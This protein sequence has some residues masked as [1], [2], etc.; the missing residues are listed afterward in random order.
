VTARD[1][2]FLRSGLAFVILVVV[3]LVVGGSTPGSDD[4]AEVAAFYDEHQV[5]QFV[6]TFLLAATVPF[7]VLFAVGLAER[8]GDGRR[9]GQVTVAGAILAGSAIL[10][11]AAIHFALLD[12]ADRNAAEPIPALSALDGSTWVAF[13]AGFGVMM[14]GAGGLL[15]NAG[16]RRWLGGIALVLGIALFVPFADF[17]A[18]L[19]TLV[20]IVVA[21][22][23]LARPRVETRYAVTPS[24]A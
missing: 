11:T 4:S 8:L 24:A 16:A 14:L 18:L 3:T 5:R 20:W 21:T 6:V 9:W 2:L 7:L 23:A 17:V 19:G 22:I 12:A 15:V 1:S 13:D 10:T